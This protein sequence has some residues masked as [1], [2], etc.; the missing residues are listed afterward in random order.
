MGS[1]GETA[2]HAEDA[3]H[4]AFLEGADLVIH[5]AQYAAEEYPA[6]RQLG[7]LAGRDRR[8]LMPWPRTSGDWRSP[9][10]DPLRDDDAVDRLV[11]VCRE[12]V[13][14]AGG[15]STSSPPPKA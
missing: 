13:R 1:P 5:D 7:P 14:K 4:V 8:G 10:T 15:R 6:K 12:R 9:I 11:A 3:R 2:L